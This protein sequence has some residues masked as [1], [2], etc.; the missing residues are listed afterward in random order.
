MSGAANGQRGARRDV[1][2]IELQ[3][4]VVFPEDVVSVQLPDET[5][6]VPLRDLEGTE[7]EIAIVFPRGARVPR[8]AADVAPVCI[9]CRVAQR[10]HMPAGG[11]QVVFQGLARAHVVELHAEAGRLRVTVEDAVEREEDDSGTSSPFSTCSRSTCPGTAT[12]P[13]TSRASCG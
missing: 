10:M 4:S 1:P 13:T 8:S 7:P 12:T 3:Q 11:L 2:A 5:A 9:L 6:A